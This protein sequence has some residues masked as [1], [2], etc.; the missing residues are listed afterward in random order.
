MKRLIALAFACL[1]IPACGG[2]DAHRSPASVSPEPFP[3]PVLR[4][5]SDISCRAT[6]LG[7][8]VANFSEVAILFSGETYDTD[9]IHDV[10]AN[11]QT[12]TINTAGKYTFH[13]NLSMTPVIGGATVLLFVKKNVT[14]YLEQAEQLE[15]PG[16]ALA[17][18]VL[19]ENLFA[20]GDTIQ[21]TV[22]VIANSTGSISANAV[23]RKVA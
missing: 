5:G 14:T 23:V 4:G 6:C 3:E 7:Q 9:S 21:F 11:T 8:S 16:L 1:V 10:S 2:S 17:M 13:C 12:F 22:I 20:V 18:N 15:N 19:G